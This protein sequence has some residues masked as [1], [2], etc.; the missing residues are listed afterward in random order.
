MLPWRFGQLSIILDQ[1]DDD[2]VWGVFY[3]DVVGYLD[4]YVAPGV[5]LLRDKR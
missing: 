3:G 1:V 2:V 4:D 5:C